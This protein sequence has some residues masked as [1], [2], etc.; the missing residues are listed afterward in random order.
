[1]KAAQIKPAYVVALFVL[2]L[3]SRAFADSN[4]SANTNI[5]LT[6][7]AYDQHQLQGQGQMQGQTNDSHNQAIAAPVQGQNQNNVALGGQSGPSVIDSHAKSYSTFGPAANA[8][9]S[10]DCAGDADGISLFSFMGG[11]GYSHADESKTCRTNQTIQ[12]TC[13]N[14]RQFI[15][16][17]A[18]L[19]QNNN[20]SAAGHRILDKAIDM[21]EVCM[22][23]IKANAI[24]LELRQA[25]GK[26]FYVPPQAV[27]PVAAV[28]ASRAETVQVI[29]SNEEGVQTESIHSHSVQTETVQRER[30]G[31]YHREN[32]GPC[33]ER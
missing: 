14:A 32:F 5:G 23:G 4:T 28:S 6:S 22:M 21:I 13:D 33:C 1:M 7:G 24:N 25:Y 26:N 30:G 3:G 10:G 17:G 19:S 27:K 2:L 20:L 31:V 16:T 29:E 8:L 11:L 9:R 12:L 15:E 18:I